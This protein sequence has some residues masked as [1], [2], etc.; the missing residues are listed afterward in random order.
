[1]LDAT[2]YAAAETLR[3]GRTITIRALKP[4]DRTELVAAAGRMS[5][6]SL[7]RRFFG[8]KRHFS[9]AEISH[10][11]DIDFSRHVALV[12]L[13]RERGAENIIASARY[14]LTTEKDAEVAFLVADSYQGRGI[15][16][17]LLRHLTAI[18]REKGVE[19]FIAEVL[20]ENTG[21]LKVFAN[22]G[23]PCRKT[24]SMGSVRLALRL[25]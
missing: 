4:T 21:M 14:I 12:G 11:V 2:I 25:V 23:L 24:Q 3:D 17:L 16:G 15:G 13:A 7:Y 9:E 10:F 22:S 1:M 20:P 18:A 5:P 6:K 8:P 19:T